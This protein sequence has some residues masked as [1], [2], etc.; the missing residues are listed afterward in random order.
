MTILTVLMLQKGH[1][2]M[3]TG[4]RI[5]NLRKEK[6]LTQTEL[7]HKIGYKDK[8]ALSKIERG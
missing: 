1:I 6:G 7:A 2:H 8:T 3:N 4:E 5:K